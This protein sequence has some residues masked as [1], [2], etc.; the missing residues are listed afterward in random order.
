DQI[1][2]VRATIADEAFK[3]PSALQPRLQRGEFAQD[4][5]VIAVPDGGEVVRIVFGEKRVARPE[6]GI[7]DSEM[8]LQNLAASGNRTKPFPRGGAAT[9]VAAQI[10]QRLFAFED[11]RLARFLC[12]C[13]VRRHI[14]TV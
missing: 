13:A 14:G 4:A 11:R 12:P 9:I 7:M 2:Q 3:L 8:F 1:K 5:A 10:R 6:R